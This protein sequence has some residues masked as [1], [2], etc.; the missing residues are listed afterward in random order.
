MKKEEKK[1]K[2]WFVYFANYVGKWRWEE[3]FVR[4]RNYKEAKILAE[5]HALGFPKGVIYTKK[6]SFIKIK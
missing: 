4:E 1:Y 2:F 3:I 5:R 6:P